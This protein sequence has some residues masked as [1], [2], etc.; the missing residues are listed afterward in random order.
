MRRDAPQWTPSSR[1]SRWGGS[2]TSRLL[3]REVRIQFLKPTTTHGDGA[4][5]GE[6]GRQPTVRKDHRTKSWE[7]Y[8][9][10]R[11]DHG[12]P[13]TSDDSSRPRASSAAAAAVTH[14]GGGGS[15]QGCITAS[16]QWSV[17][18]ALVTTGPSLRI[19]SGEKRGAGWGSVCV[20]AN[21]GQLGS[22]RDRRGSGKVTL[23]APQRSFCF[24]SGG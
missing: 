20:Q 1:L 8:S 14:V 10:S 4:S 5:G 13:V 24:K 9:R 15:R 17:P 7:I 6:M 18:P 19:W 22:L 21:L 3:W 16:A 23:P 12:L 11:L 2:R